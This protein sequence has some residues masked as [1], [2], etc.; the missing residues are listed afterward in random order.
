MAEH[1]DASPSP[2]E[3]PVPRAAVTE[4]LHSERERTRAAYVAIPALEDKIVQKATVTVLNAIYEQDFLPC[5]YGFRPGRS[6]H[7]ALDAIGRTMCRGPMAYVLEADIQGYFDAIVRDQLMAFVERRVG[8]GSILRLLRKWIHIGVIEDG[9]LRVTQTG[10]GQGQVISPL[11]A[12]VYLHYVLDE[13]FEHEVKPRLRGQAAEIRYADDC[14]RPKPLLLRDER[15][16]HHEYPK[17]VSS[18]GPGATGRP[19][20]SKQDRHNVLEG[21]ARSGVVRSPGRRQTCRPQ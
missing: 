1:S 4:G 7:D 9:R 13:W 11:V 12:N 17:S 8:D 14:A 19:V 18:L 15:S 6:P 21:S 5:S 3:S 10:T 20:P 2:R 16:P